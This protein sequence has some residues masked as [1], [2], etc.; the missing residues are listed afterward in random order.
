MINL[1]RQLKSDIQYNIRDRVLFSSFFFVVFMVFSYVVP[2]IYYQYLDNHQY[3]AFTQPIS[4]GKK[5]YTACEKQTFITHIK[6]DIDSDI[7]I[8]SRLYLTIS[9]NQYKIIKQYNVSSFL[10]SQPEIQTF[11]TE[12]SLP[13]DL[14][15]G[16]YFYR[17]VL[18]YKIRGITKLSPFFTDTFSVKGGETK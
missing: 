10:K 1:L 6:I 2:R 14:T 13:C 3:I 12:T 9:T 5:V 7:D 18:V 17:G 15:P 4:F 16:I 11:I 8:Q